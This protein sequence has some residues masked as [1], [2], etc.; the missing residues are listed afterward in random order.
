MNEMLGME[1]ITLNQ[2]VKWLR[3]SGSMIIVTNHT[4]T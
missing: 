1:A 3:V 2:M 4:I